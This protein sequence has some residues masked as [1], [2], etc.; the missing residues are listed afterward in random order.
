M[1]WTKSTASNPNGSCV[2]TAWVTATDSG[3]DCCVQAKALPEGGILMRDSKDKEG[4]HLH[5]TPEEWNAFLA[6]VER[7]EFTI[8]AL[9]E[10]AATS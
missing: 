6:G 3:G 9:Q 7:R 8:P 10:A 2:E 4:P 1:N 5:F